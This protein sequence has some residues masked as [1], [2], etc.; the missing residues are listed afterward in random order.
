VLLVTLLLLEL[1][2]QLQSLAQQLLQEQL[3]CLTER[4]G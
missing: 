1:Y 2:L 3:V 4:C